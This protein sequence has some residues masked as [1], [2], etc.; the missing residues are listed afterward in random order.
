[1]IKYCTECLLPSTKPHLFFQDGVCN[2]CLN[3][4]NRIEIDYAARQVEFKKIADELKLNNKSGWD[5][6]VPVSGGKDSTYQV[7]KI[8][9]FGLKPLCVT[10]S[11][12][13]LSEIGRYNIE[14][15]KRLGVDLIEFSPNINIRRKLNRAGLKLVGD[16][17]WPEHVGIFT[18]PVSIAIKFQ[19][20]AIFWGE[21]SQNEY[22]GPESAINKNELDRR[23][24]EEFGGLIGLRV[25]DLIGTE[26]LKREDLIPYFYP[27]EKQ[28]NQGNVRGYFLGHYFPWDG[29]N[30]FLISQAFGF[31]DYG[32]PVEGSMVSYENLDNFQHGIHDYFK[33]LKFGYGRTTDQVSLHIRRKRITREEGKQIVSLH[34]GKFPT[35]YLGKRIESILEDIGMTSQEFTSICDKFTNKKLFLQN[36]TGTLIRNTSG[37]LIKTNYDN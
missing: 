22:G 19:I 20:G 36:Q 28:L 34:E 1:M 16:I 6:V 29:L 26:E 8:L 21:N 27:D 9:E 3:F 32:R 33:F 10:S 35:T 5:C 4:K 2:A 11:T 25:E 18:I 31:K 13:D 23:W 14:N 12:C 17:A 30:N 7:V 15:L 24:L 37:D